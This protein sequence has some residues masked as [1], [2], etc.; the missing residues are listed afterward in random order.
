MI[1]KI[2]KS[3]QKWKKLLSP[4]AYQIL[5]RGDTELP[6]VNEFNSFYEKGI[7]VCGAC[8]LP[9][10]NSQSKYNS[11]TGWPSFSKPIRKRNVMLIRHSSNKTEVKCSRCESHL[12]H[13][14]DDGPP[15]TGERYCLNSAALKFKKSKK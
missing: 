14:F 8:H 10:F 11:G 13:F 12:G 1:K 3:E 7:Y 5:R 4:F 6:F 2:I 15:P 9:V